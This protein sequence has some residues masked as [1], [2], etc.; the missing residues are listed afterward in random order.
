MK[1]RKYKVINRRFQLYV[2]KMI[3]GEFDN[4]SEE[5]VAKAIGVSWC[6]L[7]RWK[8][9]A[10]WQFILEERRKRYGK[11]TVRVDHALV[12]SA[13]TGDVRAME[14]YY[15][16]FDGYLPTSKQINVHEIDDSLIDDELSKLMQRKL[17]TARAISAPAIPSSELDAGRGA[18]VAG[19][20]QDQALSP[21]K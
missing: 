14:L 1:G 4:V 13:C 20:N 11:H 3:V 2:E 19:V 15:T 7:S 16:R 8:R 9:K 17:D 5:N 10:P 21:A 12:E 6:T 18:E